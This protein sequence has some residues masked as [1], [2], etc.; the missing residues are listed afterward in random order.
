[1]EPR[2]TDNSMIKLREWFSK[3]LFMNGLPL[4]EGDMRALALSSYRDREVFKALSNHP[5]S[6]DKSLNFE[7]L[8]KLLCKLGKHVAKC[9]HLINATIGLHSYLARG[10]RIEV[11]SSSPEKRTNLVPRTSKIENISNRVFKPEERNMFL[12]K[13]SQTCSSKELDLK[14]AKEAAKG[15]TRVHCEL[16]VLDHFE[17]TNGRFLFEQDRYIGCSKPACYLCYLFISCH[18][19]RYA[20]PPSHQKLYMNWRL[21]DIYGNQPSAGIRFNQQCEILNHMIQTVRRDLRQDI[22]TRGGQRRYCPDSTAGGTSTIVDIDCD[23]NLS[24]S[25]N[26]SLEELLGELKMTDHSY[27]SP[28][29]PSIG[30]GP[31]IHD[32][33][34]PSTCEVTE[35]ESD[36]V[37]DDGG[38]DI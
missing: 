3:T 16:L 25:N 6:S 23:L 32:T 24:G 21:P 28:Q 5:G 31:S 35:N 18:P 11:I 15:K 10:F 1:M 2:A 30:P 17:Q 26:L 22:T 33:S 34:L 12:Q 14:L 13:L 37:S 7:R 36:D 4:G 29:S 9:K 19:R 20:R 38:V 27:R 8:F